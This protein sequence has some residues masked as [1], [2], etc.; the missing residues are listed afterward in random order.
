MQLLSQRRKTQKAYLF[1]INTNTE[2]PDADLQPAVSWIKYTK[3]SLWS[4]ANT[5][6]MRKLQ[7]LRY[8][9]FSWVKIKHSQGQVTSNTW[10]KTQLVQWQSLYDYLCITQE[11]RY[12]VPW[13]FRSLWHCVSLSTGWSTTVFRLYPAQEEK[14]LKL[15]WLTI[16]SLSTLW[17]YYLSVIFSFFFLPQI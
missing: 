7:F 4:N 9:Y 13:I 14:Q 10:L 3:E 1:T 11:L 6:S 12:K 17:C 15:I 16:H 5:A 2:N 8:S